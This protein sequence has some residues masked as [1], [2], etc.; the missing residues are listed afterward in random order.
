MF[1]GG[2]SGKLISVTF[3]VVAGLRGLL[4]PS[5]FFLTIS[6]FDLDLLVISS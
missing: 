2:G 1:C 5:D 6:S 4:F 3:L